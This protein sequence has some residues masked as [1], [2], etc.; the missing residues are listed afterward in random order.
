MLWLAGVRRD[1]VLRDIALA[2]RCPACVL[3][4]HP[5]RPPAP[6]GTE[7]SIG[8]RGPGFQADQ[9]GRPAPSGS[10]PMATERLIR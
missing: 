7:R 3:E 9:R 8:R 10:R 5:P 6:R 4:G 1:L 2:E